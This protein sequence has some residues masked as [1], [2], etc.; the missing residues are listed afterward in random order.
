MKV[1]EAADVRERYAGMGVE[2]APSTPE[3]AAA[4]LRSETEKYAKVVKAIGLRID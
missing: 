4:Y 2:P 3:R 1:L